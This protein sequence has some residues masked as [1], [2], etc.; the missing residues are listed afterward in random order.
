MRPP[1]TGEFGEAAVP[2]LAGPEAALYNDL[3]TWREQ[4]ARSIARTHIGM[5]SSRIGQAAN[6]VLFSL[7]ALAIAEDRH[8]VDPGTVWTIAETGDGESRLPEILSTFGDLWAGTDGTAGTG[9]NP[10]GIPVIDDT[11]IREIAGRLT[12]ADRPYDLSQ[13]PLASVAVILD[14]YLTRTVRRSAAHQAIVIDRP[15]TGAWQVEISPALADYAAGRTLAAVCAGRSPDDPLPL[16][17]IDPACGAGRMLLAAYRYLRSL[18]GND[19]PSDLLRHTLHG[20]DPDPHAVAAARMMLALAAC[21]DRDGSAN[22]PEFIPAFREYLAIL[23]ATIQCG[24]A[25]V[26][27]TIADDESWAFCPVRERH[28]LRPFAWQEYFPEVLLPGGFDAVLCCPPEYPV[29]AREWLRQYFQR[30]YTVYDPGAGLSAYVVEKSLAILR[31][32][33][34]A[35]IVGSDRWLRARSGALLRTFL[36]ERQPEEILTAGKDS[37]FLLLANARTFRPFIVRNAG[38]APAGADAIR[39][40]PG[41]PVDPR[42]LAAGGWV[43]RDTRGKRLVEKISRDTTPLGEYVLG[44]IRYGAGTRPVPSSHGGRDRIIFSASAVP[45]RFELAGNRAA[46]G[47]GTGIIMSGSRYLLGLLNSRLAEF[48]FRSIWEETGDPGDVVALFP[49]ATP[50]FDD[51]VQAARHGR[52]ESLVTERLALARHRTLARS[53]RELQAIN[54]EM[55]STEKQIESLVYGIYG[56]SMDEISFV[57]SSLPSEKPLSSGKRS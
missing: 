1:G 53:P 24:N 31:P 29:P 22:S 21:S 39:E 7:L 48:L 41:F 45:P 6:Q 19:E 37:C 34:V 43:F 51:P 25:L 2:V 56:L 5:R 27:P 38:P 12:G 57:E 10:E 9:R 52:L 17:V 55:V 49:V 28:E 13:I 23:S 35:G 18:P 20:I 8:L 15:E 54:A 33:G 47:P 3:C 36:L 50:D 4:L 42:D 32:Y 46:P 16:R 11:L 44:E 30:H 26:G 14:R 40:I